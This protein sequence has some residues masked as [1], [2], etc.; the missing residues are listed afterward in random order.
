MQHSDFEIGTEFL[1]ETGRWRCTDIGTRTVIPIKVS[2]PGYPIWKSLT[3]ALRACRSALIAPPHRT[4]DGNR[5][6]NGESA[7]TNGRTVP[8]KNVNVAST[9][10]KAD[11]GIRNGHDG[12]PF[13]NKEK[14]LPTS[15]TYRE[16]TH[17]TPGVNSRGGQRIVRGDTSGRLYYTRNHYDTF[18]V[19]R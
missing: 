1:T 14:K 3:Q 19:L 7:V 5:R 2:D 4:Y 17:R 18:W 15:E 10:A 9:V 16:W 12:K 11:A 8:A 13:L 6:S